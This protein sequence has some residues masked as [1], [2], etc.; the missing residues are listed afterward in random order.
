[1]GVHGIARDLAAAGLGTLKPIAADPVAG[2][3]PCPI[4]IEDPER[5]PGFL[6]PRDPRRPQ[7]P[8]ARLAAAAAEGGRASGRSARWST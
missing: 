8:L 1:M 6:R 2:S 4:E 7:R 5:L 3:F